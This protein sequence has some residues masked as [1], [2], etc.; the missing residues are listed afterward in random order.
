[1]KSLAIG[2]TGFALLVK[3]NAGSRLIINEEIVAAR[4]EGRAEIEI[5]LRG[6]FFA[7]VQGKQRWFRPLYPVRR[8]EITIEQNILLRNV[9][10]F[11]PDIEVLSRGFE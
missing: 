2:A 11:R 4:D 8:E 5:V 6:V 10:L 3:R 7:A 1:M 9:H